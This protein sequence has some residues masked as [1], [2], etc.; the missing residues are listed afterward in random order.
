[1]YHQCLTCDIV[2]H[3]SLYYL[4]TEIVSFIMRMILKAVRDDDRSQPLL[5]LMERKLI[6]VTLVVALPPLAHT[7][8]TI[9]VVCRC[10]LYLRKSRTLIENCPVSCQS[11]HHNKKQ[12]QRR[13]DSKMNLRN[14][15]I[16]NF[17]ISSQ[18]S[19]VYSVTIMSL[20]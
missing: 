9:T 6:L 18:R 12:P 19:C 17:I 11:S 10:Q 13:E 7:G 15:F 14:S 8:A 16:L 5:L 1:M 20:F 2:V 4:N 3:T